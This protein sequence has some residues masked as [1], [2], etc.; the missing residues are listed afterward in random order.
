MSPPLS[1]DGYGQ[2]V[3]AQ[4]SHCVVTAIRC[5]RRDESNVLR[6][7]TT[8]GRPFLDIYS[9][10]IFRSENPVCAV[11]AEA[12]P[13]LTIRTNHIAALGDM[14]KVHKDSSEEVT[15]SHTT[16]PTYPTEARVVSRQGRTVVQVRSRN[17]MNTWYD[18]DV[19]SAV[20]EQGG[21]TA[22]AKLESIESL[23]EHMPDLRH[24]FTVIYK[25]LKL[26]AMPNWRRFRLAKRERIVQISC[27]GSRNDNCSNI[28][29]EAILHPETK[30]MPTTSPLAGV[31]ITHGFVTRVSC[32][33]AA[34]CA[35]VHTYQPVVADR[36]YEQ[37]K[38]TCV[39]HIN[40]Y[41]QIAMKIRGVGKVVQ[42]RKVRP[43]HV[44][45]QDY[46]GKN[47]ARLDWLCSNQASGLYL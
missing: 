28:D 16:S 34:V 15:L 3:D 11:L 4:S 46:E 29:G 36:L 42:F 33:Q 21:W 9:P 12:F 31:S 45:K 20:C 2:P 32:T 40:R 37:T 41:P 8:S 17:D 10:G 6:C 22:L 14:W 25:L 44:P 39:N 1:Y 43:F 27:L 35:V 38:N 19:L 30:P 5:I 7:K 23:L 24:Y 47:L 26:V 13:D 18:G